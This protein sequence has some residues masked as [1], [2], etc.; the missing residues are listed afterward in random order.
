[1]L[2]I[3]FYWAFRK[4]SSSW[5]KHRFL[6]QQE[7]NSPK[8]VTT[9]ITRILPIRFNCHSA[10]SEFH[11]TI[12]SGHVFTKILSN[13]LISFQ[14]GASKIIDSVQIS[15][16]YFYS[17]STEFFVGLVWYRTNFTS[18]AGFA[19]FGALCTNLYGPLDTH[20]ALPKRYHKYT[21]TQVGQGIQIPSPSRRKSNVR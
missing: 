5:F 2:A 17:V 15:T 19:N 9:V 21:S 20:W 10:Q 18:R 16:G 1:M 4:F 3:Y 14:V 11:S 7:W 13:R 6:W 12:N 8:R